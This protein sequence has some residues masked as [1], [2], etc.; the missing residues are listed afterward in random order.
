M[1]INKCIVC[2]KDFEAKN[3]WQKYCGY[4]CC[5]AM[6]AVRHFDISCLM[7]EIKKMRKPK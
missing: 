5:Q 7:R 6:W 2:A 3:Y 1:V 4:K